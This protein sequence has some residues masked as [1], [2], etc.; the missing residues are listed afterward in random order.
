MKKRF[1]I[2]AGLLLLGMS[3]EAQTCSKVV[4]FAAADASGAYPVVVTGNWIGSWIQKNAKKHPDICF[5]QSPV[6][7]RANYLIVLSQSA[8]YLTGFDPVVRRD[9]ST[10]PVSGTGTVT[11]NYGG[12]WNYSYNGTVTTTTTTHENAPYTINSRTIY[13]YAYGDGGSIISQRYHVYS[14]KSGGDTANSAGY[15]IGN[16]LLAINARGRLLNSVVKD[17][18]N[19]KNSG[20]SP[21]EVAKVQKTS[22][23]TNPSPP[24][25]LPRSVSEAQPAVDASIDI[26]SSPSG[27]DVEMDGSFVGNSPSNIGVSPGDHTISMKK[28]G[29]KI[30]ERKIKVTS[31]NVNITAELEP[32]GK[33]PALRAAIATT[34]QL[35]E[36]KQ[37][38]E[39]AA[40]QPPLATIPPTSKTV[41]TAIPENIGVVAITSD[42]PGAEVYVD[43]SPVG[44]APVTMSLKAGQHYIRMF[45]KD[46]RN[47]SQLIMVV[48]GS[49]LNLTAKLE[50]IGVGD[51]DLPHR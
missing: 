35:E 3:A 28:N 29:Y 38:T 10:T 37:K 16:A 42:P 25:V 18:E 1:L 48:R 47:W 49:E 24:A 30:W 7:G 13:A 14:T 31:G 27:A 44:K 17:I 39:A 2:A 12:M 51:Q 20:E 11:D 23:Q 8:G 15:N 6:E 32:E 22:F 43:D 41:S 9:T 45:D 50:K 26:T 34:P 36:S 46:C 21:V 4:S 5:S 19:H 33:Q 40:S